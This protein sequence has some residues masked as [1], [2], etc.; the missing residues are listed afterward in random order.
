MKN[1]F[2]KFPKAFTLIEL[3]IVVAII[4]ILAAIA[5]PNFLE[6]QVRAKVSRAKADMRTVATA[7]EAYRVDFNR[8]PRSQ[9]I[10]IIEQRMAPLTTPVAYMTKIPDDVFG[11]QDVEFSRWFFPTSSNPKYRTFD[12]LT[13]FEL[14]TGGREH[15]S[16][17][18]VLVNDRGFRF[19]FQWYLASK[20]PDR[21]VGLALGPTEAAVPYD[22]T[23]GTISQ[24]DIIRIGPLGQLN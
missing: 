24:G 11:S 23:N 18:N 19:G 16:I 22:P 9:G 4:A 15:Q 17:Y 2:V 20:G 3:L 6:A 1:P 14:P 13:F 5:V 7:L 12:Y 21:Q 10:D 8:Y